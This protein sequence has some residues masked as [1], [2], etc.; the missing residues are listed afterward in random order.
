MLERIHQ[1]LYSLSF[2]LLTVLG[3]YYA[4]MQQYVSTDTPS[5]LDFSTDVLI[6]EVE[7]R[8]RSFAFLED[9]T[10]PDLYSLTRPPYNKIRA[11]SENDS[12]NDENLENSGSPDFAMLLKEDFC[13]LIGGYVQTFHNR[14]IAVSLAHSEHLKRQYDDLYIQYRVIR[15]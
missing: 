1:Y 2:A 10:D 12:E 14:Q 8:V 4:Q 11:V 3:L 15:L 7:G 13:N 6:R 5:D 9:K